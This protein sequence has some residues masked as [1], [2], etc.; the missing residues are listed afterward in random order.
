MD[1]SMFPSWLRPSIRVFEPAERLFNEMSR[2]F[3]ERGILIQK[4]YTHLVEAKK[5]V[6]QQ[7]LILKRKRTSVLEEFE[8]LKTIKRIQKDENDFDFLVILFKLKSLLN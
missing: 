6:K 3:S 1:R 7:D 4:S 2:F 5:Q 8:Q